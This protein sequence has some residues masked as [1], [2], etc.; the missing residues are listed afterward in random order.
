VNTY[1]YSLLFLTIILSSTAFAAGGGGH[2]SDLIYPAVNFF[3][4]VGVMVWKLKK[5]LARSF[6]ENKKEI[7]SIFN[8]AEEKDKEAQL[9]FEMYKKKIGNINSDITRI[10]GETNTEISRY[11]EQIENE[12]RNNVE[13]LKSD[14][15][16]KIEI[17]KE[18]LKTDLYNQFVE[19]IIGKTKN[20]LNSD[21]KSKKI[22]TGNIVGQL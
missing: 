6:Q 17:E 19:D 8:I 12:A 18:R 22:V 10:E 3:A 7:E 11:K 9:K 14:Q 13:R 15:K 4:L 16:N 5:P 20:K 2:I 21:Q 1:K